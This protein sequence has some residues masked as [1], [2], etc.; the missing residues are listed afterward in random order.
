MSGEVLDILSEIFYLTGEAQKEFQVLHQELLALPTYQS[1][2]LFAHISK[3]TGQIDLNNLHAYL[4]LSNTNFGLGIPGRQ[5][6]EHTILQISGHTSHSRLYLDQIER[7]LGKQ[8]SGTPQNSINDLANPN[9]E[10]NC[11]ISSIFTV[12]AKFQHQ[13]CLLSQTLTAN[14]FFNIEKVYDLLDRAKKGFINV[15][16]IVEFMISL[17]GGRRL[18]EQEVASKAEAAFGRIDIDRDG[19]IGLRDWKSFL[20]GMKTVDVKETP[21]K[22]ENS[23]ANAELQNAPISSANHSQFNSNNYSSS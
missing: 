22:E 14:K 16:D 19:K 15:N 18:T 21:K 1:S 12:E 6:L 10:L 8:N 11:L 5:D 2:V 7:Y 4:E 17:H 13:I 23:F 9:S 3:K 20:L